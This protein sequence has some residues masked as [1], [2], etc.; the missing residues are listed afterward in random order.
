[1]PASIR[2]NWLKMQGDVTAVQ[3]LLQQGAEPNAKDNAGWTPL[4]CTIDIVPLCTGIGNS[5][6]L[7]GHASC[8]CYGVIFHRTS[9]SVYWSL[10]SNKSVYYHG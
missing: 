7:W 2:Y 1:M 3:A 5:A 4:V 8:T 6:F 9:R 10:P